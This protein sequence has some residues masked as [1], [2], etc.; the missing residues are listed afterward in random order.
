MS[1]KV[2]KHV[3]LD[4]ARA[5][6]LQYDRAV[7]DFGTVANTGSDTT[8][9]AASKILITFEAVVNNHKS[10]TDGETYWV[11]AGAEYL[12]KA[13]VWVGQSSFTG[14][15]ASIVSVSICLR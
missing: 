10:F 2:G 8:L 6:Y 14:K 3:R 5:L 7:L 12:N 1:I 9:P 11:S 4:P 13:K 15:V